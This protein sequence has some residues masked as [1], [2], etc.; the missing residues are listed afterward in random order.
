MEAGR[1]DEALEVLR[2]LKSE[3]LYDFA[4]RDA[5]FRTDDRGVELTGDEEASWQR[6]SR[7][8]EADAQLGA[9]ID[10]LSRL[11]EAGRLSVSE[12]KRL[13]ELLAG[14][15]SAESARAE[16]IRAFL[17]QDTAR[18]A[19]RDTRSREVKA[20]GLARE[21][22]RFGPDTA[23]AFYLMTDDRLRVLVATR[24]SQTEHQ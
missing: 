7:A 2:L 3:E 17:A 23:L 14:Q 20:E 1:I 9:E 6:Y 22:Q 24:A 19:R 10:R 13:E 12:Q 5:S 11:R 8:L 21:M 18:T 4:L 15:R 16:R